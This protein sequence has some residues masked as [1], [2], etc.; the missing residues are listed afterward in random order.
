MGRRKSCYVCLKKKSVTQFKVYRKKYKNNIYT[1]VENRCKECRKEY[2]KKYS[3]KYRKAYREKC[4]KLRREYKN[5]HPWIKKFYTIHARCNNKNNHYYKKG[6]KNFLT[7][8]D[9]KFLWFRDKA[10]L[11]KNPSIDR[12]DG[13][14]HYTLK[15]CRFIELSE[16]HKR[17]FRNPKRKESGKNS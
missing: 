7:V 12:I 17:N 5:K 1:Y 6:I 9:L 3:R 4:Y 15:N 14:K 11:L 10:W 13:T 2:S 16:N 8:A